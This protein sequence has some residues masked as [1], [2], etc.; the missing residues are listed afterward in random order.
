M[1][2]KVVHT[3]NLNFKTDT[4]S[5]NGRIYPKEVLEKSLLEKLKNK[6]SIPILLDRIPYPQSVDDSSLLFNKAGDATSY[7]IKPDGDITVD[8]IPLD[9]PKGVLLKRILDTCEFTTDGLGDIDD[10][11]VISNFILNYIFACQKT[12]DVEK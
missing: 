4:P 2:E 9:T 10:N 1:S 3:I 8:I 7:I 5:L 12:E 11:N 6:G